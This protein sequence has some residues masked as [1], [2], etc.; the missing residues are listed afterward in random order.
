MIRAQSPL[1]GFGDGPDSAAYGRIFVAAT[2]QAL[3]NVAMGR[4]GDGFRGFVRGRKVAGHSIARV[5]T[6]G[7]IANASA[8]RGKAAG[9]EGW[10]KLVWQIAG[11]SRFEDADR[12]FCLKPGAL[13]ILPMSAD[14][15]CQLEKGFDGLV[16]VFNPA[17]RKEWAR[18]ARDHMLRPIEPSGA[19]IA[20]RAG[21]ASMLRHATGE[22]T[23]NLACDAALD[24]V[25]RAIAHTQA[26]P[27]A[28]LRRAAALV[29]QRL[30][31]SG[32]GPV[33]LARDL[34][35]SRRS[36]YEM[37]AQAGS[38]PAS[39]IREIRLDHAR[40]DI[41]HAPA[42]GEPDANRLG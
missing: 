13:A 33:E 11:S 42:I 19:I 7:A 41:L 24:L 5:R 18:I 28:R 36:L 20:A 16:M 34:G 12:A 21:I 32:Y 39:F 25:F 22:S 17:V 30:A 14:Y 38:T 10:C 35:V 40:R 2:T 26:P 9:L 23:D 1:A 29:E 37:F 6:S 8:T 31:D 3:P 15:Q 4:L 27:A